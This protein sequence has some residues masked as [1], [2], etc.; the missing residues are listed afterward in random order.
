MLLTPFGPTEGIYPGAEVEVFG[1]PPQFLAGGHLLGAVV[2]CLGRIVQRPGSVKCGLVELRS[3]QVSLGGA[4][5][6]A[7]SRMAVETPF[8]TGVRAIDAFLTLGCGQRMSIF[9]E[10]GV[11]KTTLL[12]I[13]AKRSTAAVNVIALIGERGRE[14]AQLL[15]D[16]LDA[17]T[18][19][20]SV[21][22]VSTSDEP[23]ACRMS[24]GLT[25]LSIAEYFRD[26]G[27]EVLLQIDSLTRLLRALREVG[28]AAGEIPVR[29]GYPPSAFARLP[30]IIERVGRNSCGSIT[31]LFTLLLSSE[32]DEDPMVEEIKGLTDGHIVLRREFAE[33]GQYPAIDISASLSRV[34]E[35][36][37][38]RRLL[39]AARTLRR[40]FS[41]IDRDKELVALGGTAD[42]ELAAA[43]QMEPELQAFLAQ[44]AEES[45]SFDGTAAR[46][47]ELARE[48]AVRAKGPGGP[49]TERVSETQRPLTGLERTPQST[50]PLLPAAGL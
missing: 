3:Q 9:A 4:A 2:D 12:G 36:L 26:Q 11:G 18:L 45:A 6:A 14:I 34:Q 5:P 28:L 23:A 40:A 31:G 19:S 29:R 1:G 35:Q 13:I 43:L 47:I 24:A 48:F 41:R 15:R 39:E 17:E 49:G 7:L 46:L 8:F 10:P 44:G 22:V 27:L 32:F 20:R 37:V 33:R 16:T 38:D 25:A 21:V 50:R 42:R 30:A